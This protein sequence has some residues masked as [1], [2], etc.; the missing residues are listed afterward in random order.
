MGT[1]ARCSHKVF[2]GIVRAIESD[3]RDKK[4]QRELERESGRNFFKGLACETREEV[5]ENSEFYNGDHLI[6]QW[7]YC[8]PSLLRWGWRHLHAPS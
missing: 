3:E 8:F 5:V 4:R 7:Y 2:E 6:I 1:E